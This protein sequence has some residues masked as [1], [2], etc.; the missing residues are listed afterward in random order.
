[1]LAKFSFKSSNR[2]FLSIPITSVK[3]IQD[4]EKTSPCFNSVRSSLM[5]HNLVVLNIPSPRQLTRH[6]AST[7]SSL[8]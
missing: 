8:Q 6:L 3:Y 4:N 1:M 7:L 5:Y 2:M